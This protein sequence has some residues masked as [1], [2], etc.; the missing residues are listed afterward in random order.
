MA[1]YY[2]RE[3]AAELDVDPDK[4]NLSPTEADK[5]NLSRPLPTAVSRYLAGET[6]EE[7]IARQAASVRELYLWLFSDTAEYKDLISQVLISRVADADSSI[8]R[9]NS[10]LEL[11]R[12]LA[13]AKFTRMDLERR[14]PQLYGSTQQITQDTSITV[15]IAPPPRIVDA[16]NARVIS[17]DRVNTEGDET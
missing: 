5:Q 10:K 2:L 14:R 6:M 15:H 11:S 9:A 17:T 16:G 12:S 3:L 8:H 13:L 7:L 1:N 4:Q